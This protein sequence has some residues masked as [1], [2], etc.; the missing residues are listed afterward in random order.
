[1]KPATAARGALNTVA[2]KS[3]SKP[4][5]S[6]RMSKSTLLDVDGLRHTIEPSINYAYV[7]PVRHAPRYTIPQIRWTIARAAHLPHHLSG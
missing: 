2:W 6:G 7:T 3:L 1:M 4:Q 5:P